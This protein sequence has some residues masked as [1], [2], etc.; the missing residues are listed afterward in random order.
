M[1]LSSDD[2]IVVAGSCCGQL[3]FN[4]KMPARLVIYHTF[5]AYKR[6]VTASA[7]IFRPVNASSGGSNPHPSPHLPFQQPTLP[8]S[9]ILFPLKW[10]AMH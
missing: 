9:S 1:I 5:T 6:E 7:V 10:L 4:T 2:D 8:S 3:G